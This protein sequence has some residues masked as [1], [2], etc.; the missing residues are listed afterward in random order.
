MT[1]DELIDLTL[2]KIDDIGIHDM[3]TKISLL[4]AINSLRRGDMG[5]SSESSSA[6][7]IYSTIMHSSPVRDSLKSSNRFS[8]SNASSG[9]VSQDNFFDDDSVIEDRRKG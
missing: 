1:G 7:R 9:E 4:Q 5:D 6:G 3:H 8:Q 2:D